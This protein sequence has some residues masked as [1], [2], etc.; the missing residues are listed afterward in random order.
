M[1]DLSFG[2]SLSG[3]NWALVGESRK[4]SASIG[5]FESTSFSK[6]FFNEFQKILIYFFRENSYPMTIAQVYSDPAVAK[7]FNN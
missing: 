7:N 4:G 1:L 6:Y 3:V 5:R 2:G